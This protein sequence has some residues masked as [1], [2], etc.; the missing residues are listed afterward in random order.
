MKYL[1]TFILFFS[2]VVPAYASEVTGTLTTG[3]TTGNGVTG[4][5]IEKP[6]ASPD[7]GT[8]SS[9]QSVSLSAT[10]AT[11]IR[12]FFN[13]TNLDSE[14]TC[15]GTVP[16]VYSSPVDVSGS[17]LLRA[18]ACYSGNASS[19]SSFTY[20]IES[21]SSPGSPGGGGGGGGGGGSAP[22]KSNVYDFDSNG[23]V[24]IL[25]FNTMMV[26]WGSTTATNAMGDVDGNNT[27]DIFDFNAF[28]VNW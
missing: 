28:I 15:T 6:A 1:L 9:A 8:Y 24:D 12:F 20:V 2:M 11:E 14:L 17:G 7:A 3:V 22:P 23:N 21:A 16:T 26:Y 4:M 27:V 5:V 13:T 10:G 18:V 25:D 19:I